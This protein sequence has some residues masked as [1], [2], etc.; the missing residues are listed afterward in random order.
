MKTHRIAA[1]IVLTILIVSQ[2]ACCDQLVDIGE[3]LAIPLNQTSTAEALVAEKT[4]A[5]TA[6]AALQEDCNAYE[7][8][9]I[10]AVITE[11]AQYDTWSSCQYYLRV[12]NTLPNQEIWVWL[13][14]IHA[15]EAGIDRDEWDS[16]TVEAGSLEEWAFGGD[17]QND[18]SFGH[19]YVSEIAAILA[20]PECSEMRSRTNAIP[21]A[22]PVEWFCGP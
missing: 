5:A 8:I 18:G 3:E 22:R 13:H 1:I 6:T 10:E 2:A 4:F 7:Y 21:L 15:T 20:V 9:A 11:Q 17:F 14:H 16:A 12:T 19:S